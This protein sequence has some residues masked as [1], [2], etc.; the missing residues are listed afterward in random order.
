[1]AKKKLPLKAPKATKTT[2]KGGGKMNPFAKGKR[3]C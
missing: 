2:P 3:G 1:M